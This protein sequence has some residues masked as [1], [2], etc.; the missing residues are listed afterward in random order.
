MI[1]IKPWLFKPLLI[2][3][4]AIRMTNSGIET[5]QRFPGA[6]LKNFMDLM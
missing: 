5:V 1:F 4:K 2:A 6:G 3:S